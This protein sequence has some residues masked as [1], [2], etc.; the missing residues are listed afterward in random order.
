MNIMHWITTLQVTAV[1]LRSRAY[2]LGDDSQ[3][4]MLL[5]SSVQILSR[6]L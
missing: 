6:W 2:F 3:H 1:K 4:L 5:G